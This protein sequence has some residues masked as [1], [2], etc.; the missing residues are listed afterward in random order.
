[1]IEKEIIN[2]A[3]SID[4]IRCAIKDCDRVIDAIESKR[5]NTE[6]GLRSVGK[7]FLYL[8]FKT[9]DGARTDGSEILID[10][11][12]EEVASAIATV[13][14]LI[15]KRFLESVQENI[16]ELKKILGDEKL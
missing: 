10:I 3:R 12:D 14:K 11:N 1:M 8:D 2:C 9:T 15:K 6:G 5:I 13:H 16:A 7:M 4:N